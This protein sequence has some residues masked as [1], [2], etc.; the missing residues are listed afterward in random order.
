MYD[1]HNLKKSSRLD[2]DIG[3]A[4]A[5]QGILTAIQPQ[6]DSVT[7]ANNAWSGVEHYV[8]VVPCAPC[9]MTCHADVS[10]KTCTIQLCILHLS[11]FVVN[12]TQNTEK[13]RFAVCTKAWQILACVCNVAVLEGCKLCNCSAT[14]RN[15]WEMIAFPAWESTLASWLPGRPLGGGRQGAGWGQS[16]SWLSRETLSAALVT[17]FLVTDKNLYYYLYLSCSSFFK[18]KQGTMLKHS[19]PVHY[20]VLSH[21]F[22]VL[23]ASYLGYWVLGFNADPTPSPA[24]PCRRKT[25]GFQ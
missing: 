12:H 7:D 22:W 17:V 15:P 5:L 18:V 4:Q 13:V 21:W 20:A 2:T 9:M 25:L 14:D 8:T 23:S 1:W 10:F 11:R 16:M 3:I 24:M 6:L 19:E